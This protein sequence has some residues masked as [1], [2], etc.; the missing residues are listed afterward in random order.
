[1]QP[2]QRKSPVLG[3]D[4]AGAENVEASNLKANS[5]TN[6]IAMPPAGWRI[7]MRRTHANRR[8]K[9]RAKILA[10]RHWRVAVVDAL[11]IRP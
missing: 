2:D 9:G 3:R 4:Q 6:V 5:I 7:A 1:M 8:Y 11:E 10:V